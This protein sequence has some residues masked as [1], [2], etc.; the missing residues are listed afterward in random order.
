[1]RWEQFGKKFSAYWNVERSERKELIMGNTKY[2]S[3]GEMPTCVPALHAGLP[4]LVI[5]ETVAGARV[6]APPPVSA[7]SGGGKKGAR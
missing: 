2:Y 7:N 6:T 5:C 1:M 4:S 3:S